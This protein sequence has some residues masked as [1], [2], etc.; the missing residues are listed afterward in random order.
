M[1]HDGI[2]EVAAAEAWLARFNAKRDPEAPNATFFHLFL[3]ACAHALHERPGLNRFIMNGRVYQRNAVQLSFTAKR[4][5]HDDE[6]IVTRKFTFEKNEPFAACVGRLS[7]T[8]TRARAGERDHADKEVALVTRL[9]GFVLDLALA[10][11]KWLD[12]H[13]LL[14]KA[15]IE[16][17]PMY[18]SL[19][20]ANLGSL[21]LD[22][23]TH[24]M[25]EYGTI[26]LFGTVGKIGPRWVAADNGEL[27][28]KRTV[29]VRWSFDDRINDGFYCAASLR[30]VADV[31]ENPEG[32]LG[33]PD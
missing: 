19:F 4:G 5:F 33:S 9:P 30:A 21:G 1:Y 26:S 27:V 28:V 22:R 23:V 18:A 12:R 29:E 32:M 20:V 11:L 16:P 14:P 15:M 8:V 13:N 31:I 25:Y 17:D 3:W 24:H 10:I 2:Y 7:G 6:P